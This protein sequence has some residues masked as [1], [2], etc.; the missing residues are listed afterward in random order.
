MNTIVK[1]NAA[2][3]APMQWSELREG[4]ICYDPMIGQDKEFQIMSVS[5][6]PQR[7]IIQWTTS[8]SSNTDESRWV[9]VR[10]EPLPEMEIPH[11]ATED[12]PGA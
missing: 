5:D 1:R 10:M 4:M 2:A 7:V 8:S 3:I 9:F 12:M 11:P 6:N